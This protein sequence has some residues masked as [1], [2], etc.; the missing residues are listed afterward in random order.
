MIPLSFFLAG[1]A[2]EKLEKDIIKWRRYY[3]WWQFFMVQKF[4]K[5]AYGPLY[6][7]SHNPYGLH[8]LLHN[9]KIY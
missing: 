2:W 7:Y 9:R 4:V 6:K 8:D 3:E 1:F 5:L